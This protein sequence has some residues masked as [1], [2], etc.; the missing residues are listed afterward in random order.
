M[1]Q[2]LEDGRANPEWLAA[3]CGK[4]TGSRFADL[5]AV[6]KTGPSVSR[7]NLVAAVAAERITGAVAETFVTRAMQRGLDLEPVA[8][9]AYEESLARLPEGHEL[10][11]MLVEEVGFCQSVELEHVGVSPDGL[12][13]SDGLVEIKCPDS[14]SR[15]LDALRSGGDKTYNDH[16]WQVQ[17]QLM[18]TGRRWCD[19]VSFDPRFPEGLQ[20]AICRVD[21]D[22][23]MIQKLHAACV[24]GQIEV[25][26][27]VAEMQ[28][29]QG[30][31]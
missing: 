25:E 3:R 11:G 7:L 13:G 21:R 27:I 30:A 16:R 6:T 4:F 24:E 19:V 22:E 15:H 23:D 2:H 14:M 9:A 18:V 1:K 17:G 10:R 8:R 12:V 5:M 26:R 29:L 20:S 31:A 28:L